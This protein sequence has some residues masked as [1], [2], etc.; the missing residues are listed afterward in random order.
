MKES[1]VE[2]LTS[3]DDPESCVGAREGTGEASTGAHMGGV[4]SRE[5]RPIQGADAVD[6]SGRQYTRA[7][8]GE[9][10]GDPARSKTSSTCGNSMRENRE[11]PGLPSQ[12]NLKGRAGKATSHTP[13]MDGP[14]KSDS[15]VVPTKTPNNV[16]GPAAEAS[17]GRGL[18]KENALQDNTPRT[19]SRVHGVQSGLER[20]R[21]AARRNKRERFSALFHH[22]TVDRLRSAFHAVKREAAPG[23][24]GVTWQQYE[25]ALEENLRGLHKRLQT[26]AYRARPSRRVYIPKSDGRQRPLGIASI[27]DKVA[28]RAVVE[29]LN[30]IYETDFLGF[31]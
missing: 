3:H 22:I 5:N 4:L 12:G 9:R 17:E 29:V 31:S 13:A 14:G 19:Q 26:G 6:L 11:I 7:R 27:E 8:H 24:D 1:H 25:E 30:A 20:V 28:Q 15:P 16:G 10:T 18:T 23:V 2:G 21:Q